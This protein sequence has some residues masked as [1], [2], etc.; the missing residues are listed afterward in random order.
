VWKVTA[1]TPYKEHALATKAPNL[2]LSTVRWLDAPAR[3][4]EFVTL[5][6]IPDSEGLALSREDFVRGT[7][8]KLGQLNT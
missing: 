3:R 2:Q 7:Q 6:A 8:A 4:L 5:Y 1:G